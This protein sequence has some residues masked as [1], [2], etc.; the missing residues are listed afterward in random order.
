M[1]V[2]NLVPD[3][4]STDGSTPYPHVSDCFMAQL[5]TM[6]LIASSS[7]AAAGCAKKPA[8]VSDR[9]DFSR[10]S[11]NMSDHRTGCFECIEC[12][13]GCDDC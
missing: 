3:R 6:V 8:S 2:G 13:E 7:C 4:N 1:V 9:P 10:C 5:T 12:C 11:S